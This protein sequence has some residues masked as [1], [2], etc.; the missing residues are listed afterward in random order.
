MDGI[1]ELRTAVCAANQALVRHGLVL[2][3]WGNVSGIRRDAGLVAIKPSGL[4]YSELTP[5]RIVVTDLSGQVVA[6]RLRPS[7]D[8]HTHLALYRAFPQIGG[9]AHSHSHYATAFAQACR[10]LPCLG[11]THADHFCGTVPVTRALRDHELAADY[12]R[13]TGAV[14]AELFADRDPLAVPGALVA[15]HGPFTWGPSPAAAVTNRV[16]LEAVARLALD[17]WQ[18]NRTAAAID[19]ALLDCHYQR[20][21][22]PE[23]YYGQRQDQ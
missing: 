13:N 2:C 21:H 11:T 8:L 16:V 14:I 10:A 15:H 7:S 6:G 9:V 20:K 17:T 1:E 3:T 22:G 23:A 18:L 12:E 4:P 19:P 5:E